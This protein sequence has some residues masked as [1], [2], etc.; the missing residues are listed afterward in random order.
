MNGN[1]SSP[2]WTCSRYKKIGICMACAICGAEIV[3]IKQLQLFLKDKGYEYGCCN[4][5]ADI[6]Y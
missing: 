2:K 3:T 1:L 6:S 4:Q 5:I